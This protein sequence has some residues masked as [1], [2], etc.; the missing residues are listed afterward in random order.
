MSDAEMPQRIMERKPVGRRSVGWPKL[1]WMD[2]VVED[3]RKMGIKSWWRVARDKVM[4][5]S[6]AGSRGSHWAVVLMMMKNTLSLRLF[7]IYIIFACFNCL[8]LK[9]NPILQTQ[10]GRKS[11][12]QQYLVWNCSVYLV[13]G[14]IQ[15]SLKWIQCFWEF[16]DGGSN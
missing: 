9:S 1:R 12:R 2:G 4:E 15:A 11:C 6:S 14:H 7:P 8:F 5:E 3:L 10:S 16:F 13:C